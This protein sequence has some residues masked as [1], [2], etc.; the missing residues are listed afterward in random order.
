MTFDHQYIL[1]PSCEQ[2]HMELLSIELAR[3]IIKIIK[4][5]DNIYVFDV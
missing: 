5:Y 2:W 1:A 3:N 4:L